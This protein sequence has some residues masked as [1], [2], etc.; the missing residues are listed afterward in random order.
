MSLEVMWSNSPAH[1]GSPRVFNVWS[2]TEVWSLQFHALYRASVQKLCLKCPESYRECTSR[3]FL[4]S[5][6]CFLTFNRSLRNNKKM[7]ESSVV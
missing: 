2:P 6:L 3:V 1:A 4:R 5:V 7:D